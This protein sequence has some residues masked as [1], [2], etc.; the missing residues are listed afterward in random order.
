MKCL[1]VPIRPQ[2]PSEWYRRGYQTPRGGWENYDIHHILPREFGGG[3]DFLNL[4]PVERQTHQDLFNSF[5][6]DFIGL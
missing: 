3:N 1:D 5:W 6:R 2:S 4:M